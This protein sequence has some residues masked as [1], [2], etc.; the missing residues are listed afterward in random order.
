LLVVDDEPEILSLLAAQFGHEFDVLPATNAREARAILA[1]RDVDF[2]LSDQY[3]LDNTPNP[4]S[5]IQLLEWVRHHRSATVRILMTGQASFQ[6][7]LDAINRGQVHRF[8]LK[9]INAVALRETL[10][11]AARTLVLER[12][13]EQLLAEMRQLNQELELRVQ[14][15]TRELEEANR[16]LKY[17]NSILEKMALTDPLTGL[18]N[19]R[20]MD[21]LVRT[22]LQ[23]R[24][25]S[26]APLSLLIIDAD[27][28]KDINTRY[29]LPGGDHALIWLAQVLAQTVRSV[30]AVGRIGGEE[31][32]V[33]APE[34][35][36]DG[37]MSL[38]ERLRLAVA[39]GRTMYH[40]QGITLTVSIGAAIVD[41]ESPIS[42]EQLK[43]LA[44]SSLAEA[45]QTGRN[46]SIGRSF[47]AVAELS[48][49]S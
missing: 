22:E 45:K 43:D 8:L 36:Y 20:A 40:D 5:G 3:L 47:P 32:L 12:S 30:D 29:L 41:P 24:S 48:A 49:G 38:A 33:L 42:Y 10:T 26:P 44:A 37:A 21:R 39:G 18:P 2:V 14:Q 13:H 7:A 19:R 31:F 4:E 9:P 15:R 23:R 28:F 46:R 17:K 1:H 34:T 25:R 16:Q 6:D 35:G 11:E 27:N